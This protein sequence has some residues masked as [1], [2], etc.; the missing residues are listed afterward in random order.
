MAGDALSRILREHGEDLLTTLSERLTPTDL[1][2]LMMEVYRLRGTRQSPGAL[3][4]QHQENRFLRP[5]P[6]DPRT[7]ME[8]EALAFRLAGPM[9][10]PID[11]SPLAPLGTSSS[12]TTVS[13][14][15]VVSTARNT[16]VM[17]DPTNAMA[18]E[19]A[20]RRRHYLRSGRKK[21]R[22]RLCCG[23]R[24]TRAQ[25][26]SGPKA[27][28]H[29]RLFAAVSSGQDE[30]SYR[31]ESEEVANHIGFHLEVLNAWPYRAYTIRVMVTNFDGTALEEAQGR[32]IANIQD[33]FS[34]VTVQADSDRETGRTY[35]RG[36]C[37]Q[38]HLTDA[39]GEEFF[40]VDGGVT[41]WTQQLLSNHK[42]RF[43]IS[44]MGTERLCS[45]FGP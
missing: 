1:Q 38:I 45:L 13:Q 39:A 33:R 19:C 17:A 5:S 26:I 15:N 9:F 25:S 42:E 18:L 22:V 40:L 3:L 11:L 4:E 8:Y 30:G 21:E 32:V 20:V 7:T 12:V 14:N 29:F 37:F 36:L 41:D 27:W 31:F 10:E 6:M 28:A 16:E 23:Q 2:S 35:Y 44:G 24:V 43:V 34:D